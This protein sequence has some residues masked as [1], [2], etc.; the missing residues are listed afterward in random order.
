[1]LSLLVK[2]RFWITAVIYC[3]GQAWCGSGSTEG[4]YIN[5]QGHERSHVFISV[6]STGGHCSK[7]GI[8]QNGIERHYSG[9][10]MITMI[11]VVSVLIIAVGIE[12][13]KSSRTASQITQ[14]TG[15]ESL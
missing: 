4:P 6:L 5:A 1:M 3:D 9:N 7:I 14:F 11:S 8:E 15:I 10:C 12:N 13:W 2:I